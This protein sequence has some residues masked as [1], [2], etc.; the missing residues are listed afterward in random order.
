[1]PCSPVAAFS[2]SAVARP[3]AKEGN[4]PTRQGDGPRRVA[5]RGG[6]E[7]GAQD[8]PVFK[9]KGGIGRPAAFAI[10]SLPLPV[11]ANLY[12]EMKF[13]SRRPAGTNFRQATFLGVRD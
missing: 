7:L 12:N 3:R 11:K 9:P 6:G 10:I 1:M 5:Q 2:S 4:S 13:S 8:M